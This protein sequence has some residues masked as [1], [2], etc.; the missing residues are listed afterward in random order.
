MDDGRDDRFSD[1]WRSMAQEPSQNLT[2]IASRS[3]HR[4][5]IGGSTSTIDIS[6]IEATRHYARHCALIRRHRE[7]REKR[8]RE[9]GKE[10]QGKEGE[11]KF[12]DSEIFE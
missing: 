4:N 1:S 2:K 9:I 6:L 5:R 10:T 11:R 7:K 8:A 12:S 3:L